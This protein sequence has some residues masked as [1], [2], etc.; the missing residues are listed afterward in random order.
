MSFVIGQTSRNPPRQ[1]ACYHLRPIHPIC[2]QIQRAGRHIIATSCCYFLT[3]TRLQSSLSLLGPSNEIS[4][5]DVQT[6]VKE[7]GLGTDGGGAFMWR[8]VW[9]EESSRIW[10]DV[11]G[12][13]PSHMVLRRD[14]R[15]NSRFRNAGASVDIRRTQTLMLN[16]GAE[17]VCVR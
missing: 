10:R 9:D 1:L 13:C 14:I 7:H 12:G 2:P 5:F 17:E 15:S 3:K 8:A 16:E 6:F 11:I 4:S